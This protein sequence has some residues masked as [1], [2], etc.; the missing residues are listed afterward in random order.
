MII[1]GEAI[2]MGKNSGMLPRQEWDEINVSHARVKTPE[3]V[4]M[5]ASKEMK[6]LLKEMKRQNRKGKK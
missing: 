6:Q 2:Y 1:Y 4:E 5:V 3:K